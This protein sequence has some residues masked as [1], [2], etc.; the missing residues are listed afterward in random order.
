MSTS[1][2]PL[3]A[4]VAETL[5]RAITTGQLEPGAE[6]PSESQLCEEYG[7]S[8]ITVRKALS[9]LEQEGL[10]VSGQGRP[11]RVRQ[12]TPFDHHPMTNERID[13]RERDK[14]SYVA[15]VIRAG[16]EPSTSLTMRIEA[17]DAEI[18]GLLRINQD[19]LVCIREVTR[20]VDDQPW[21]VQLSFY[22][23]DLAQEAGLVTPHDVPQGTVRALA[24]AG[25]VEVGYI[26]AIT[27]RMASPE[28][29]RRLEIGTG[30]PLLVLTRTAGTTERP[31]RVTRSLFPSDRNRL[32][33][34][35]DDVTGIQ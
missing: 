13:Q 8:R 5:R 2:A 25:H 3:H 34:K 32:V 4:Q 7:V 27:A 16:R 20:Y 28:E 23:M 14:D 26:D 1:P 10:V 35:I 11:R 15:E 19:D 21:S 18:A 31:T 9:T 12:F 22:P 17:A 29:A 33:Y 30:T 6:L 24:D